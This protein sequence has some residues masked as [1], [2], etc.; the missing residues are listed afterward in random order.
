VKSPRMPEGFRLDPAGGRAFVNLPAGKRSAA[1]GSVVAL[2][3]PGGEVLWETKLV[4]RAGN[5]P[6]AY[7]ADR[8]RVFIATRR[9]AYL[10]ALDAADGKV[11]GECECPAE[12]DDL[13]YDAPTKRVAVLGG[14]S[15]PTATGPGGVGA[16]LDLFALD[17]DGRPT[18]VGSNPLPPHARTG[19]HAPDLR[20]IFVGVPATAES[21]A[22]VREYR[23]P[24]PPPPPH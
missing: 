5:F 7:D 23:L 10:I 6:M 13:F 17:G 3:L 24:A 2:K 8:G 19:A 11:L 20:L 16:S 4:G 15:P 21:P 9:P 12:S 22:E 14:G 18:R 1:D